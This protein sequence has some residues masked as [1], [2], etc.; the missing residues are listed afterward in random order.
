MSPIL[1]DTI[2]EVDR[3]LLAHPCQLSFEDLVY[4]QGV[5]EFYEASDFPQ[6]GHWSTERLR[7]AAPLLERQPPKHSNP[8]LEDILLAVS[9]WVT[10]ANARSNAL[11]GFIY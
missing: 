8:D 2:S 6:F 7:A 3:A 1:L 9:D 10:V 5:F 11:F 4:G